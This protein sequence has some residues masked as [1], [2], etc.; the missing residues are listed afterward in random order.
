MYGQRFITRRG[1][2]G[3][4]ADVS[5]AHILSM[6]SYFFTTYSKD[7]KQRREW[8]RENA[9]FASQYRAQLLPQA[10]ARCFSPVT[11]AL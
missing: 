1:F 2:L 8:R 11:L 3:V 6:V 5:R 7:V 4:V 9:N 10:C